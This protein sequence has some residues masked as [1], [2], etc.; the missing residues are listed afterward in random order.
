MKHF[1]FALELIHILF[2]NAYYHRICSEY[3]ALQRKFGEVNV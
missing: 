1:I 2:K 3:A